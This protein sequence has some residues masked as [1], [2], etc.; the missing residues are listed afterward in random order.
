M[1]TNLKSKS[2]SLKFFI[3]A[4]FLFGCRKRRQPQAF[5]YVIS[6]SDPS[7]NLIFVK[8]KFAVCSKSP[9][10]FTKLPKIEFFCHFLLIMHIQ[11]RNI[12]I[13][14]GSLSSLAALPSG[15]DLDLHIGGIDLHIP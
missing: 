2:R 4:S 7:P 11:N 12:G 15:I 10:I 1:N 3:I 9:A 13:Q 14:G 8:P 6:H 5:P